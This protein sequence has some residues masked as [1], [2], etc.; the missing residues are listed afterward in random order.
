MRPSFTGQPKESD[1][2]VERNS[3]PVCVCFGL[4]LGTRPVFKTP[5]NSYNFFKNDRDMHR[6][7]IG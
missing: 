2:S 4:A 3:V 7:F 6:N 5:E 1:V